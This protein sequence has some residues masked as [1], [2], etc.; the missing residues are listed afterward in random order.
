MGIEYPENQPLIVDLSEHNLPY[1]IT[2]AIYSDGKEIPVEELR[3]F[4]E[5]DWFAR[6]Q[7]RIE[8]M[9]GNGIPLGDLGELIVIEDQELD[10]N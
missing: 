10:L 4:I 2:H 3:S 1:G 6:N 8:E 7:E 9:S 5:S